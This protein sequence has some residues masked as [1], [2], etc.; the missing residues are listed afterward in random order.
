MQMEFLDIF[1]GVN[2][3]KALKFYEDNLKDD[4]PIVPERYL[5]DMI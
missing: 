3:K 2:D 4:D 5:L 1:S